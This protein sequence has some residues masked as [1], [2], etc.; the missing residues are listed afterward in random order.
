MCMIV[1]VGVHSIEKS[2][3]VHT[4][5]WQFFNRSVFLVGTHIDR[6]GS[7]PLYLSLVVC[8]AVSG[9]FVIFTVQICCIATVCSYSFLGLHLSILSEN[10]IHQYIVDR[11]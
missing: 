2:S 11:L 5:D 9:S 6:I 4:R 1:Y 8:K 10:C 3:N 7:V